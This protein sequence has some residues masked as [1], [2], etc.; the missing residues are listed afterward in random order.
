MSG[1][2]RRLDRLKANHAKAGSWDAVFQAMSDDDLSLCISFIQ[3]RL[4]ELPDEEGASTPGLHHSMLT[5][6]HLQQ[7]I[8]DARHWAANQG[9]EA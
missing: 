5:G 2:A 1:I 8:S 4:S 9:Y 3:H 7:I 6:V